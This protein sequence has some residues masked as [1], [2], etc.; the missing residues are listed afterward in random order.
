MRTSKFSD[1]RKRKIILEKDQ[2]GLTVQQICSRY[3][4]SVNTFYLWRKELIKNVADSVPAEILDRQV[5][6]NLDSENKILRRLY[7][8]L[9]A[10]NY[11]LA[12]FLER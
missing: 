11:E 4:I 2:D 6:A 9:S 5:E 8:N 12:K 10:H 1:E 7:I 3:K